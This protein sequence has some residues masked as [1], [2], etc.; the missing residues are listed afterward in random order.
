M[1]TNRIENIIE[2]EKK[3]QVIDEIGV[4]DLEKKLAATKNQHCGLKPSNW[5]KKV[6]L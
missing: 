1:I 2:G 4:P 6:R 5:E 3:K